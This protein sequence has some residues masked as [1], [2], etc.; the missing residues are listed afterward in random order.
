MASD[1]LIGLIDGLGWPLIAS[2][3]SCRS[4]IA[5]DCLNGSCR[6]VLFQA[7]NSNHLAAL[8]RQEAEHELA[9]KGLELDL[10][11]YYE[12][13]LDQKDTLLE[14]AEERGAV[15]ARSA[16]ATELEALHAE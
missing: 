7:V 11:V 10:C 9:L 14:N 8:E 4:V 2:D 15:E 13:K 5:S 1:G 16:A 6:S 12:E 3:G